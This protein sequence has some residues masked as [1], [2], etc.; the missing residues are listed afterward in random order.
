LTVF[1]GSG[2]DESKLATKFWNSVVLIPPVES[3]LVCKEIKQRLRS[4]TLNDGPR[5]CMCI[6]SLDLFV[7][8]LVFSARFSTT[9]TK[10]KQEKSMRGELTSNKLFRNIIHVFLEKLYDEVA[11][12]Q[13]ALEEEKRIHAIEKRNEQVRK[14]FRKQAEVNRSKVSFF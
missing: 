13:Q 9:K 1:D 6:T 7:F 2:E 10:T 12:L 4:R 3:T 5:K 8:L 14:L 11:V